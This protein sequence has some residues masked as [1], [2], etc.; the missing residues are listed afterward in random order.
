MWNSHLFINL[1]FNLSDLFVPN[2]FFSRLWK[3]QLMR[4]FCSIFAR[5][6]NETCSSLIL[7]QEQYLLRTYWVLHVWFFS[8]RACWEPFLYLTIFSI[9]AHF[10]Y[11]FFHNRQIDF[12]FI[13][14]KYMN[15]LNFL[16]KYYIFLSIW[17]P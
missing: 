17:T 5:K 9:T 14:L 8:K 4:L 16:Q 7:P 3:D 12:Q 13:Y 1:F 2:T 10:W 6:L 15:K 11:N